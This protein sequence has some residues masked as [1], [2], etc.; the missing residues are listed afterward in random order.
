MSLSTLIINVAYVALF[1]STFTQTIP[2]LRSF[3]VV[4]AICFIVFGSMVGNWSMVAWNVVTGVLNSRQLIIHARR[5]RSVVL[6]AEDESFRQRWFEDLDVFDFASLWSMGEDVRLEDER[7]I[8]GGEENNSL[9]LVV[10]GVVEVRPDGDPFRLEAGSL[11]G[12]MSLVSG[13]PATAD[14]DA[15]GSVRLRQWSHERLKTLDELNPRAGRAFQRFLAREL[16]VK[17]LR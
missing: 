14:V 6:N 1:A 2:R 4:A 10:E 7:M 16:A 5:R 13:N 3:L 17:A 12:E 9:W 11:V 15:I 8:E